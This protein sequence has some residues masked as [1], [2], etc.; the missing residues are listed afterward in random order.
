M[1]KVATNGTDKVAAKHVEVGGGVPEPF[2]DCKVSP[3][4]YNRF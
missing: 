2:P 1:S 4:F 3:L